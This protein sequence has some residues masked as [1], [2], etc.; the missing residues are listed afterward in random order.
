[1]TRRCEITGK[2]AQVGNKVSHANNKTIRR[3]SPNL[4]NASL[5]SEVL[6]RKINVRVSVNGLR[7]IDH[8]GGLDA[9]LLATAPSKLPDVLRPLKAQVVAKMAKNAA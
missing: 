6:Q 1:M 8:K 4:Q 2:G 9:Y 7:T 5:Y 3:F